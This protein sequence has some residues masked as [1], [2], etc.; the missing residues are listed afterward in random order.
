MTLQQINYIITISEEGSLN[1]A[2]EVLYVAQPSLTS[3]IKEVEKEI[4]VTLFNRSGKGVTLTNDGAEFLLYAR[5][6]YSQYN[7]LLEKFGQTGNLK[8]QFGV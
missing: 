5:Q 4:G 2:A 6:V 3:A 7:I 1:K 8:K